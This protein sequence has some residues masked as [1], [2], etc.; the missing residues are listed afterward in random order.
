MT[1][2]VCRRGIALALA[3]AALLGVA[4]GAAPADGAPGCGRHGQAPAAATDH[5]LRTSVLCLLNRIR[6]NRGIRP[7]EFNESLRRSA[8]AHSVSM[9]R[10]R[11]LSHYGPAGSTVTTRVLRAG[12]LTSVSRFRVAENIGAGGGQEFGS[13]RAIV[14]AWMRSPGHRQNILDRGLRDFGV[15]VARGNPYGHDRNA[16]TYTVDFGARWR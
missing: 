11:T 6:E 1:G 15:G 2:P 8:S 4:P 14:N 13:P 16:A 5:E 10:S 7:L 3:L 12:Y 9:V